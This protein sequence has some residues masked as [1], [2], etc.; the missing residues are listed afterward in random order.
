MWRR[1]V[2]VCLL[3]L[4]P[5]LAWGQ[6]VPERLLPGGSQI[7]FRWDG[8]EKHRVAY[9]K[10]GAGKMMKEETGKFFAALWDYGLQL[11]DVG[12][13]KA[14]PQVAELIK[15]IPPVL[16][17]LHQHGLLLGIEVRSFNPPQIE[18][19]FIMPKA[20]G[21]KG[22]LPTL[23]K[24]LA[25]LA[26]VEFRETMV[27][28]RTIYELGG[29]PVQF[30][31]WS[32]ANNDLVLVV[33]T[34]SP[35]DRAKA[36]PAESFAKSKAYARLAEFKQFETWSQAHIDL[37]GLLGKVGELAPQADQIISQLGLKGIDNMSFH[38]GFAGGAERSVVEVSTPGPRTGLLAH[39]NRKTITLAD[40]PPMPSDATSFS[41][42]NFNMRNLY[43]SG[44]TIAEAAVNVFAPGAAD[45]KESIRQIEGLLGIKFGEDLFGSFGDM[46]V[47]YSSPSEGPGIFSG[48]Y[49]FKVKDEKK[50]ADS[51]DGIFKAIPPFPF[52]E[53]IYQKRAYRG[54]EIMELKIKTPQGEF[55]V[56]NMAIHKGWFMFAS[57][58]QSIYGFILRSNGE[59]PVWKA[60]PELTKALADFPKEFTAIAVSDPRPTVE[61]F[62]SF[63]PTVMTLAN[64][65]LPN[66]LPGAPVFDIS[67]IPHAQFAVRNLSPTISVS[68]DDGKKVRVQ[69]RAALS[70]PF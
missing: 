6:N 69:S 13:R 1:F 12:L 28:Q 52:I 35:A 15:D 25:S 29:G 68:T 39:M 70:M 53:V 18:A 37:A 3:I 47:S 64:S 44:I 32:E 61:G 22:S 43:D 62:L 45:P 5:S 11:L 48:A 36:L 8:M 54:G 51:L 66:V 67:V 60:S 4:A 34:S 26:R 57:Y 17:D 63:A 21:S 46:S 40:L 24:K 30:G 16:V 9:D 31:W 10:A 58:P 49:L 14:D 42:S 59:L 23:I 7:Y 41:A 27:G 20:G 50:L 65:I 19:V 33:G 56:G 2:P 55:P 38:S